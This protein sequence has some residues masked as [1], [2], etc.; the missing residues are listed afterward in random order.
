MH[1]C[2]PFQPPSFAFLC[3]SLPGHLCVPQGVVTPE[4]SLYMALVPEPFGTTMNL[5]DHRFSPICSY[6]FIY[7]FRMK[8]A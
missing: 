1:R 2:R 3:L 4:N 7:M 5:L 8:H 6:N